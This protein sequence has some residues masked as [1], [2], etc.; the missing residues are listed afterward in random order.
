[1]KA[2]SAEQR[3]PEEKQCRELVRR[4]QAAINGLDLPAVVTLLADEQPVSVHPFPQPRMQ[5]GACA[6]DAS[7][8]LAMA[9]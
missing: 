1:M 7:Y 8:G 6:N 3:A 9:A 5:A 4:F 2:G